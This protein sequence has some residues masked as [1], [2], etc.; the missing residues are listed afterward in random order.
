M[1]IEFLD[2]VT[3]DLKRDT[4]QCGCLAAAGT[5]IDRGNRQEPAVCAASLACLAARRQ[6][7]ASKSIR[8]GKAGMAS[9][10]GF[11]RQGRAQEIFL[12]TARPGTGLETACR[13]AA[14]AASLVM[15][16]GTP[17]QTLRHAVTRFDDGS[18]AGPLG[19]LLDAMSVH[20]LEGGK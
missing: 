4:A 11:D 14:V 10:V 7:L 17:I 1:G 3:D 13:D 9:P 15:Q 20:L 12:G 19:E 8:S 2:P 16:Y 5:I 18:A 6:D